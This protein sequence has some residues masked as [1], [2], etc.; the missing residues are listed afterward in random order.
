MSFLRILICFSPIIAAISLAGAARADIIQLATGAELIIAFE[1]PG[2]STSIFPTT[3]GLD[4]AGSVPAGSAVA[5]IPGSSAQYYSGILL[6]AT[7][8]SMNGLASLPLFD[9]DA[10]R[11]GLPT[12]DL[13]ADVTTGAA[14]GTAMA[15]AQVAVSLNAAEAIFG[16]G[17]E[18]EFVLKNL[19]GQIT[20][21]LGPGYSLSNAI[22][23]P[24]TTAN[25]Q[26]QTAGYLQNLEVTA[27]PTLFTVASVPEP[28]GICLAI[29]GGAILFWMRSWVKRRI[30]R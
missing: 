13:V 28:A 18:A 19:G 30:K 26:M 3:I 14:G 1:I 11:L 24:L 29:A 5:A 8:Q 17:G 10:W 27:A 12:G 9:A 4:L 2:N 7:L 6:Q 21:G 23:A 25:G 20:I 16:T 22:L 15:D